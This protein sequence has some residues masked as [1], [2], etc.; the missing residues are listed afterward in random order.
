MSFIKKNTQKI[1]RVCHKPVRPSLGYFGLGWSKT[2]SVMDCALVP[3]TVYVSNLIL[4]TF[5][6]FIP[7]HFRHYLLAAEFC[8]I[9]R[10]LVNFPQMSQI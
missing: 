7:L 5:M 10:G 9:C 8:C 1:E 6:K 2:R 3:G 4:Q